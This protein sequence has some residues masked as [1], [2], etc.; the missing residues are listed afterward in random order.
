VRPGHSLCRGLATSAAANDAPGHAIQRQL[1]H[2]NFN[3][4]AGYIADGRLF[5]NNAAGSAGL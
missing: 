5:R 3:Q 1:R 2:K 4:T